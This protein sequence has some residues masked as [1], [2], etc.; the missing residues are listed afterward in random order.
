MYSLV[1]STLDASSSEAQ[2]VQPKGKTGRMDIALNLI[3]KL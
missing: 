2:K 1:S 3:N